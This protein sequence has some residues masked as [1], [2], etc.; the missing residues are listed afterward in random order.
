VIFIPV[1]S[2]GHTKDA[3]IVIIDAP[4]FERLKVANPMECFTGQ[5]GVY[6]V[7]PQMPQMLICYEEMNAELEMLLR[8]GNVNAIV[9]HL[10]RG[11]KFESDAGKPGPERLQ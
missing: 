6:L 5:L 8:D 4:D 3:L 2:R 11:W 10:Q 9:R 7:N 1:E